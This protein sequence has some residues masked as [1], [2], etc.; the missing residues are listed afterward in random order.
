MLGLKSGQHKGGIAEAGII[1]GKLHE[2]QGSFV[3]SA[4]SECHNGGAVKIGCCHAVF[5]CVCHL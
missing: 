1:Y 4:A 3:P 2:L 5:L